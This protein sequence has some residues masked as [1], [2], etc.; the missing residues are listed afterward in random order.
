VTLGLSL[1]SAPH[2]GLGP[3]HLSA[4]PDTDRRIGQSSG[5]DLD[6]VACPLLTLLRVLVLWRPPAFET[7]P[8]L[9]W[10]MRAPH[11]RGVS[12]GRGRTSR[13]AHPPWGRSG[14]RRARLRRHR[15]H[16][17]GTRVDT[18]YRSGWTAQ[19][20]AGESSGSRT[21][22]WAEASVARAPAVI[23]RIGPGF[24]RCE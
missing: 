8:P 14:H 20:A 4:A 22:R 10:A 13:V 12:H 6:H 21:Q 23:R 7:A 2:L 16:A 5:D 9:L 3:T 11:R 15:D 1:G 19:Y 17:L 18:F 24:T